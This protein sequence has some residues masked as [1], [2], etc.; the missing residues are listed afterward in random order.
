MNALENT[1]STPKRKK[2]A[3]NKPTTTINSPRLSLPPEFL[4]ELDAQLAKTIQK[5][6]KKEKQKTEGDYKILETIIQEYLKS[7]LI[8]GFGINGDKVFIGHAT[9]AE[10]HDSLIEHLRQTF[11]NIIG[12]SL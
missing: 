7:F 5:E 2:R 3:I 6:L 4:K 1:N 11:I 10:Q 12:N 8:I 9:T